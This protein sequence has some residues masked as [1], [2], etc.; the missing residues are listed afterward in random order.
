MGSFSY[1]WSSLP[2]DTKVGRY[3]SIARDVVVLGKRHPIEWA[4]TSSFTYDDSFAMFRAA[5]KDFGGLYDVAPIEHR[6]KRV[7][8]GND[9]WIAA[10]VVIKP[11]VTIGDGAVVAAKSVVTRDVPPYSIVGGNPA[12]IIR[13]RFE[14]QV[15]N[16]LA[17]SRWWDF[18]FTDLNGIDVS[19]TTV[20]LQEF[21]K[22][23]EAGLLTPLEKP[24][25]S[26]GEMIASAI[27]KS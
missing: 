17:E 15:C 12:E 9:V 4:S 2:I 1:S 14:G 8:I 23:K 26:L 5:R 18:R 7:T 16:D 3:C 27:S 10:G 19:D 24:K 20:F 21:K 6:E 25:A 11:G 22:R 13:S